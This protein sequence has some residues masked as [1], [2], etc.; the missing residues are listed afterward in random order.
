MGDAPQPSQLTPPW[1]AKPLPPLPVEVEATSKVID[2]R[3][4]A[5]RATDPSMV[6]LSR[7]PSSASVIAT[8]ARTHDTLTAVF[9][10]EAARHSVST[11][12]GSFEQAAA[13]TGEPDASCMTA[14]AAAA[15]VSGWEA[16]MSTAVTAET[17]A[18]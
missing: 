15:A 4:P 12:D 16:P 17:W 11:S 8:S 1:T 5:T 6:S 7:F 13:S 10:E 9:P 3:M 18:T 2:S 14:T